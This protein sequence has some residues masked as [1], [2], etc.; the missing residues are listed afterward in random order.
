MSRISTNRALCLTVARRVDQICDRFEEAWKAVAD[1]QTPPRLEEFLAEAPESER[2]ELLRELIPLDVCYRRLHAEPIEPQFYAHLSPAPDASWLTELLVT[3]SRAEHGIPR[4]VPGSSALPGPGCRFGD[5]ELLEEV[6]RGGMGVVYRARQI[7]LNRLVALKMIRDGRLASAEEVERFRRE[8]EAAAALEHPHIVPVYEVGEHEGRCYFSMKWIEGGSLAQALN[9]P[10]PALSPKE[11]AQ[12]VA[13]IAR[14]VHHAHQHGILHR[15]LK[16]AN[17]LLQK[18]SLA[19]GRRQPAGEDKHQPADA[20]RSP[21]DSWSD[22]CPMVTDFG[23]AKR[24]ADSSVPTRSGVI[25][26]TPS[27]MAPEQA[28]GSKGLTTAVDVWGLGAI[29]YELLTGRPPFQSESILQVLQQVQEQEPERPRTLNPRVDRDLETICLK[30]LRK[31]PASRYR[32]AEALADDL[33]RWLRGLPIQARPVGTV[34]RVRKWA[35]RRPAVAGLAASLAVMTLTALLLGSWQWYTAVTASR[36]EAAARREADRLVIRLSLDKEL[37]LLEKGQISRGMLWLANTLERVNSAG[38]SDDET[39]KLCRPILANLGAWDGRLCPL[40]NLLPHSAPVV[41]VALRGD[42]EAVASVDASGRLRVWE[43]SGT[44]RSERLLEPGLP[45]LTAAFSPDGRLLATAGADEVVRVWNVETGEM[46]QRLRVPGAMRTQTIRAVAVSA[47]G[48]VAVGGGKP[49]KGKVEIAIWDANK[50]KWLRRLHGHEGPVLTLAFSPRAPILAS[51]SE[52][53][54]VRL[55]DIEKQQELRIC[56]GHRMDGR[57]HH[58]AVRA[59]AF[60]P[61]GGKLL[62]G[63]E[64]HSA[65]LWDVH[66]GG[67]LA[68]LPHQDAVEV[69]AFSADGQ[70][71]LT[72]SFDRTA[73]LWDA[74]DGQ[75]LGPPLEHPGAVNAAAFGP[76]G[77]F[78]TAGRDGTAR[79]WGLPHPEG[80]LHELAHKDSVMAVSLSADGRL[81]ATGSGR[82]VQ[83]WNAETGQDLGALSGEHGDD[84]WTLAFSRD[85]RFLLTGACDGT[86]RLWDVASRQPCLNEHGQPIVLKLGRRCRC[87]AFSPDGRSFLTSNGNPASEDTRGGAWLWQYDQGRPTGQPLAQDEI[88][89]QAAFS[90]DG[91]IAALAAGDETAQ[92]WDMRLRKPF[93]P[94]LGHQN[95]VVALDFSPDGRLL[96]TGST[97][98]SARLWDT[99]TGAAHGEPF[100]HSGAVWGVAFADERTLVTGCRDGQVRLWDVPTRAPIGPPWTHQGIVWAVACHPASRTVLT[101]GDDK[102]ARL[103][104]L[105]APWPNDVNRAR[106]QVEVRTGLT[107]DQ[108][109][110]VRWLDAVSWQQHRQALQEMLSET[111]P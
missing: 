54:T 79:V 24:V 107:L 30:C 64:D 21:C 80:C 4:N 72:G 19:N 111:R 85:G 22:V 104:R 100:E 69:V 77:V 2:D 32:S 1:T 95:R 23:L 82:G 94:A 75:P 62:S 55:W 45:V 78:V 70:R 16:S 58:Y 71:L 92:L 102:T 56:K 31:E 34:E 37:N 11:A 106:L 18:R 26:G 53:K 90:P 27:Y 59:V 84:V 36:A 47:L 99:A 103:W 39:Q 8:A 50:D 51:G 12:L 14:A 57:S 109:G 7:R 74:A 13:A 87:V 25:V 88:V 65:Q 110:V 17:I 15:D 63:S 60:S 35:W 97:D 98:K 61:D 3:S 83:L 89:W 96:A 105:P 43:A 6:A 29:L 66:T 67:A 101:G 52:D 93:G 5:Y 10:L 9:S 91:R 73:Q 42:R 41:A 44:L 33:T 40:R 81:A 76:D 20:G 108:D 38:F 28:A 86:A 46:R 68:L 48:W 49:D